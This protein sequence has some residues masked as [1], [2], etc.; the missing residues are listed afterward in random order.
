M[1]AP[2]RDL[3]RRVAAD[4]AVDPAFVEKDWAAVQVIATIAELEIDGFMP[5]F[6]GGTCLSKAYGLIQRFSEDVD[7]KTALP[8][9]FPSGNAARKVRS[10]YRQAVIDELESRGWGIVEGSVKV[11]D[12]SRYFSIHLAY[13]YSFGL[14]SSIRPNIQV[15]MTLRPPAL[16]HEERPV[17]SCVSAAG[18]ETPEVLSLACVSPVETAADKLSALVWR[19]LDAPKDIDQRDRDLVRHLHDLTALYDVAAGHEKFSGLAIALLDADA[20]RAKHSSGISELSG[21]ERVALALNIMETNDV[22][23]GDYEKFVAALSYA[24]DDSRPTF[25]AGLNA[26]KHLAEAI[27]A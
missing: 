19:V 22:Y 6:S 7:F 10:N 1:N 14:P 8:D 4:L 24:Q 11:G 3:V 13:D 17:Q 20:G 25:D 12:N 21:K 5:V 9:G 15:E 18:G 16:P 23:R 26:L 27:F 2:D